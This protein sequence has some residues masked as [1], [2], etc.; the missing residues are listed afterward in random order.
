MLFREFYY[1]MVEGVSNQMTRD[2]VATLKDL[3]AFD[4]QNPPGNEEPLIK[5]CKDFLGDLGFATNLIPIAPNR[6]NLIA[7]WRPH[8]KFP[9]TRQQLLFSGHADTVPVGDLTTWHSNPFELTEQGGNLYGRG[10]CD[11]KGSLAAFLVVAREVA[12]NTSHVKGISNVPFTIALTVDEEMGFRGITTFTQEFCVPFVGGIL[13]GE[14][15]QNIPVIGHKGVVWFHLTFHG[16]AAHAS[17]PDLGENAILMATKFCEDLMHECNA[18]WPRINDPVLGVPTINIGKITGGVKPNMVPDRCEVWLDCRTVPP[19][20][21]ATLQPQIET[22]AHK[23][24]SRVTINADHAPGEPYSL[25]KDHPFVQIVME[26]AQC[27][28]PHV[29][30]AFTEASIYHHALHL[31]VVILGPGS[32]EQ[33]HTADEY[34]SRAELEGA[35]GIYERCLKLFDEK[36]SHPG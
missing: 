7:R 25:A 19:L 6:V 17:R 2:I 1:S 31:P 34:V 15:T 8:E 22:L 21:L 18:A 23:V 9:S 33:A 14:P 4:T 29:Y 24:A 11:M 28:T 13:I 16:R 35:V 5:Y 20:D 10:T 26:A 27:A 36:C 32:I 30:T 3:V 12:T